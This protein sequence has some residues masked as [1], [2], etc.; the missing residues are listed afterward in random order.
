MVLCALRVDRFL[1]HID[2]LREAK[3]QASDFLNECDQFCWL[4]I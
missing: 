2:K 3:I 1:R 4:S